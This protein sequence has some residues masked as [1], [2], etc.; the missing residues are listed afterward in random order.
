MKARSTSQRIF[1]IINF[2]PVMVDNTTVFDLKTPNIK[3]LDH[4]KV[5]DDSVLRLEAAT[6]P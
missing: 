4:A 1:A 5:V 3:V 2:G 6:A